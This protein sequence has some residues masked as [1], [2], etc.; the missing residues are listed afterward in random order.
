M[1]SFTDLI[2]HDGYDL[3]VD[4]PRRHPDEHVVDADWDL[5]TVVPAAREDVCEKD[6]M[7]SRRCRVRRAVG[8]SSTG[9]RSS[10]LAAPAPPSLK[11][12]SIQKAFRQK[13]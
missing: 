4:K 7:R 2:P 1:K 11:V 9:R 13:P 6:R 3:M 5:G 8:V 12:Q 10:T